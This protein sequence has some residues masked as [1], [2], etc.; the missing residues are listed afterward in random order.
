M[1]LAYTIKQTDTYADVKSVLLSKWYLSKR[2]IL[3]LK[4]NNKIL[5]NEIP[6]F[7]STKVKTGDK[8]EVDIDFEEESP[9]IVPTQMKLEI[10]Y[11]DDSYIVLNKPA[12]IETHP[13]CANYS[14]TL[15]NGL[16]FYF[17]SIG[18]HRKIRPINRLDKDT[19]GIILFAKNEYIQECLIRQ[20]KENIFQ[21]EYIGKN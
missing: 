13:T 7:V 21:K 19:S 20:M 17:D 9:N 8:I 4:T 10:I 3:K 18:I 15:S 5:L 2:L 12:K 6:V 1:K 16:K 14:N 11:E